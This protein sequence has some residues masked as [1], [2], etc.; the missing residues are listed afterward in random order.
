M[1]KELTQQELAEKA[2]LEYEEQ[3]RKRYEI[4]GSICQMAS[5]S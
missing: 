5:D 4:N 1:E 3:E 2:M